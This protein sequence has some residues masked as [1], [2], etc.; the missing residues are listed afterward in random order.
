MMRRLLSPTIHGP[1]PAQL[2]APDGISLVEVEAERALLLRRRLIWCASI[3]TALACISL[4]GEA[5]DPDPVTVTFAS[6]DPSHKRALEF[7]LSGAV[8]ASG[9]I[10]LFAFALFRAVYAPPTAAGALS[11]V[12][13]MIVGAQTLTVVRGAG[14]ALFVPSEDSLQN[15][16]LQSGLAYLFTFTLASLLIPWSLRQALRPLLMCVVVHQG[17][18]LLLGRFEFLPQLAGL[19]IILGAAI[20]GIAFTF[21]RGRPSDDLA[22]LRVRSRKYDSIARD[23]VDARRIHEAIFPGA[24][25]EGPVRVAYRYRPSQHIGGDFL[26]ARRL[27][28]G[29]DAPLLVVVVDVT[30]HGVASALTV[31]RLHAEIE[32]TVAERPDTSPGQLLHRLNDY[33]HFTLAIHSVYATAFCIR[34]DEPAED[35][36][37]AVRWASGGHPPALLRRGFGPVQRLASTALM[38]GVASGPDY[39][40][41]ERATTLAPG[42][43][44]VI[45]TDGAIDA[46]TRSGQMLEIA[47]LEE[48]FKRASG[49]AEAVVESI[50]RAIESAM[51]DLPTDDTLIVAITRPSRV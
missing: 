42:D 25:S 47:G 13:W 12:S 1:A 4:F 34:I 30:G 28:D 20:P 27:G 33:L 45:Y 26:S 39:E 44:L 40:A 19:S 41:D 2:A 22:H 17:A 23:L 38:L 3:F 18:M 24:I 14:L 11:T 46:R 35:G 15:L 21:V 7:A 10:A 31:N 36:A 9:M 5:S 16:I 37:C 48:F 51:V 6:M 8:E 50:D 32:R 29:P 43:T 49:D